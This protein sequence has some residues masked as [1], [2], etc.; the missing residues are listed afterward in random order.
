LETAE[1]IVK[2][3]AHGGHS[4]PFCGHAR[5]S[6]ESILEEYIRQGFAWVG[7]AEHMPPP[8][9]QFMY[10]E[11]AAAGETVQSLRQRFDRY[12]TSGRRL[13]KQLAERIR[14]FV[15]FETESYAGGLRAAQA[16]RD[17][18]R[19]DY[20]VGS[21]H[22]VENIGFDL[23]PESYRMAAKEAGGV[24]ALYRRY[25]D[26]QYELITRLQPQIIG[27]F[28]LIRIFDPD[29]RSR[30]QKP[31]I[32]KKVQ[33]NLEAIRQRDLAIDVNVR[34]YSKG[35]DEPY[36][37][38]MILQPAIALGIPLLPGDDSHD[39]QSVG[40]GLTDCLQLLQALGTDCRWKTPPELGNL[41]R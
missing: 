28:D 27:H 39:I 32:Q 2:V 16:L 34:A 31:A 19:P 7:I 8:H 35:F 11:E 26:R 25:F 41:R 3:S 9:A 15:G 24:D 17:E 36:P 37:A 4:G 33:R 22:H 1:S 38:V 10:P 5:D 20:I 18:Y 13:Q 6:L 30:M 23:S 21:V 14:I 29:Y 12:W 40:A